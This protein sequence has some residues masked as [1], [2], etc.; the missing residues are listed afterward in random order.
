M[1][2]LSSG[3]LHLEQLAL[4]TTLILWWALMRPAMVRYYDNRKLPY[5]PAARII[6]AL[7]YVLIFLVLAFALDG[8]GEGILPHLT[9]MVPFVEPL[10]KSM[11][12]QALL[13]MA[14][15]GS[16]VSGGSTIRSPHRR[17]LSARYEIPA[18]APR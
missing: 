14:A 16:K 9:K 1:M 8:F 15:A 11:E 10:A 5:K 2:T 7:M 3:T 12:K 13:R 6:V 18:V 17:T 4:F